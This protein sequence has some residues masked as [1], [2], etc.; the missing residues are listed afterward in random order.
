METIFLFFLIYMFL[1]F[2]RDAKK[3]TKNCLMINKEYKSKLIMIQLY[4]KNNITIDE[5]NFNDLSK[6]LQQ[7]LE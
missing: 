2:Y 3:E 6:L 4:L 7:P 5:Y 1:V